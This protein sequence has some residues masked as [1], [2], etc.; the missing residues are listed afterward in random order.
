MGSS[1]SPLPQLYWSTFPLLQDL[2]IIF[3]H[4]FEAKFRLHLVLLMVPHIYS[5]RLQ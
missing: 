4:C 5:M 3:I 1:D 2:E